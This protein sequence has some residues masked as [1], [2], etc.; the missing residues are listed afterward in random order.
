[1][2]DWFTP[3]YK[4]G[5]PIRSTLNAALALKKN[6]EIYILTTDTDH[7]DTEPYPNILPDQWNTTVDDE[8]KTYYAKKKTLSRS[9]LKKQIVNVDADYLYLNHLY[10]PYFVLY[11]L[12]LKYKKK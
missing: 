10:S 3:G 11:P 2:V 5:G 4:A 6:Y 7:G 8:I 1:M 12:W 9:Q